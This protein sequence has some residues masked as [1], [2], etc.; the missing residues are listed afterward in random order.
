[1]ARGAPSG[2][3]VIFAN[4]TA[5]IAPEDRARLFDRFY[6]GDPAHSRNVDGTGLGLSIA[7]EIARAHGGDLTLEPG[8]PDEA[9]LRVWLPRE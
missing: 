7:R 2:V 5:P 9:R 8:K 4:A 3:E 6:R 1:M